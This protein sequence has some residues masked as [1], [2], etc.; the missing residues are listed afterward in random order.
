MQSSSNLILA[1]LIAGLGADDYRVREHSHKYL[2]DAGPLAI[3]HLEVAE[4]SK[5]VERRSR[6]RQIICAWREAN[7][8]KMAAAFLPKNHRQMPWAAPI[9]QV[10]W[11]VFFERVGDAQ[12]NGF[13]SGPPDWPAWREATRALIADEWRDGASDGEL[14]NIVRVLLREEREWLR[15]NPSVQYPAADLPD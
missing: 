3:Q 11:D 6:A 15:D 8:Y 1:I 14:R 10:D 7:K 5:D 12:Q 2:A 4:K 13:S 9:Q